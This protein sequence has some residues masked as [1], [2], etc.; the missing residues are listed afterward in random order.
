MLQA[1]KGNVHLLPGTAMQKMQYDYVYLME[2]KEENLL[3]PYY[4]EAGLNGRLDRELKGLHGGWDAPLSQ[5]RGTFTGHWLSAAAIIYAQ[6]I[7]I[8]KSGFP[9]SCPEEAFFTP[10]HL[11][12]LK[13]K[14]DYIV[15][16]IG[17]CQEANGNGWAFSIPEK[18]LYSLK[19]GHAFFAPQY[20]CH[21]TMM[22]LFDMYRYTQ[23]MQAMDILIKCADWFYEFTNDISRETMDHM[24]DMEE[25]GG[26][27]ELWADLY[28]VT[29]DPKHLTLMRRYERPRLTQPLSEGRDVLNNMH[30][31]AT[32][33]EI[34]GCAR[35]YEVTGE[36]RYRRIVENYWRFAVDERPAYATGGQTDG[37]I[38]SPGSRLSRRLGYRNQEHCVVYNMIRLADYLYRWSGDTK[39]LDYIESNIENGLYAQGFWSFPDPVAPAKQDYK[40]VC[41]YLPLAGGSQKKWGSKT[42]DFW[43]CHC[44]AVQ[45]NSRY[46]EW[47]YYQKEAA[48]TQNPSAE[49]E[50]AP[51]L[52]IAQY[53]PSVLD[54]TVS[55]SP[56]HLTMKESNLG[57]HILEIQEIALRMDAHPDYQQMELEIHSEYDAP[58]SLKFR[59]PWWADGDM[60]IELNGTACPYEK[61]D[62][63]A[64]L[65]R[66]FTDD[67]IL[68]QI[69]KTITVSALPDETDTVAFLD[70]PV[71]LA[72]LTDHEITLYG[73]KNA[74]RKMLK[75]SHE[76]EWN[77]WL[78]DYRLTGQS[79]SMYFKPLKDIGEEIYTVYFPVVPFPVVPR[80]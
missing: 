65:R 43:C 7:G 59:I 58:M 50:A 8:G 54:T 15:S 53:I 29:R 75:R 55:G 3:F 72:G 34:H 28:A 12:R 2:L 14:A 51:E 46:Q 1:F 69:P 45:A 6:A 23:N 49:S 38:W 35:A 73:D 63:Y 70:G 18:F 77:N 71:L 36:E 60:K 42:E 56:V 16:E 48:G 31:N 5:I 76:R 68:I 64:V 33:P 79:R 66:R 4:T 80:Q 44:T 78:P 32:I 47:I 9:K 21:K 39:Y 19:R 25:T 37:E 26:I 24:M 52:L 11:G 10:Q 57:G 20:V 67:Q 62:G 22:G 17:R 27:M 61:Q 40:V 41:Y 30:A 74:P 13:A